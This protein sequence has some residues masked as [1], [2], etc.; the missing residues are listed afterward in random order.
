MAVGMITTTL[1][2]L[3]ATDLETVQQQ[4]R[5]RYDGFAAR[6]LKLDLTRGKPASEQLELSDA[7]LALPGRDDCRAADGT[8]V[9]N[10]GVLQG[11]PELRALLAPL[12]GVAADQIVLGG[13]SSL[14]LMHD[15]IVYALLKGTCDSTRAWSREDR[16][17]FL[18][19]V[20]G[21]DRHFA[22]C[23][24]F[25]V[26]MIPVPLTG[27]GPD[28]DVVE[29]L[30]AEDAGIRGMWCIPKYSNP[31]GTVYADGTIERLAAM[32]TAAPDFRLMWD[33]AYPVHH[34][35][36]ERVEIASIVEA[37]ARHGHANR[38]FVF[39]ST[40]KI[41]YAGAGVALFASSAD[42]VRWYLARM[43]KRTI[44]GDKVNQLRHVRLLGDT[45]G[46][47]AQMDRHREII[48]P[49]FAAVLDVFSRELGGTGVASWTEPKG[50][51]FISL[52]VLDGCAR[53][54]VTLAKQAGVELTPAGS[55]HPYR[56]DP[57]DRNIRIAPTVPDL[58]D[59]APAAEGVALSVLLATTAA[60]LAGR[61]GISAQ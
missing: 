11:L 3:S 40:S 10:Y 29:R 17:A 9:R 8:D 47:L 45:A 13:N 27:E 19:P 15:A 39:G 54:V 46:L 14:G 7:L 32:T 33:N 57:D 56:R 52:D 60:L 21:Y 42:N 43:G 1:A 41:T 18:C 31:T 51:F 12:F 37:C 20:P 23:E 34:L 5:R 35:T 49:K 26:E 30:V 61:S 58:E 38:P 2:Q 4:A 28:M 25:G 48:A 36:P 24:D 44:G 55:T 6:G 59:V 16:V 22:I 50:G 53:H